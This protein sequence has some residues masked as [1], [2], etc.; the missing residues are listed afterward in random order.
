MIWR[1]PNSQRFVDN[2][3][4]DLVSGKNVVCIVP[5]PLDYDSFLKIISTKLQLYNHDWERLSLFQNIPMINDLFTLFQHGLNLKEQENI[6]KDLLKNPDLHEIWKLMAKEHFL[7][8]IAITDFDNFEKKVQNNLAKD[9]KLWSQIT[10]QSQSHDIE[11]VGVRFLVLVSPLFPQI[12]TDLFLTVHNFWGQI[13]HIDYYWSF[14]RH[15]EDKPIGSPAEFWWFQALCRALCAEDMI[16]MDMILSHKPKE[17]KDLLNLLKDHPLYKNSQKKRNKV[18]DSKLTHFLLL[19]NKPHF[20]I[21]PFER[22]LW[23]D[24]LLS[25]YSISY[26]HPVIMDEEH[27]KKSIVRAQRELYFPLVDR[28]HQLL[29]STIEKIYGGG[30]W[31]YY[32]QKDS[33]PLNVFTE[34]SHVHRFIWH[35]LPKDSYKN[36]IMKE[37]AESWKNIRNSIAHNNMIDYHDLEFAFTRYNNFIHKVFKMLV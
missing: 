27:I 20:P 35:N 2:I 13:N 36:V 19:D 3:Y 6:D 5:K 23:A 24:G 14:D 16:L 8:V 30:C 29:I 12:N 18:S 11:P 1:S 22:E 37:L 32:S 15:I 17:F 34:I 10:Q 31:D 9:L 28:I 21:Q 26:I 33:E 7:K 25:S 4:N